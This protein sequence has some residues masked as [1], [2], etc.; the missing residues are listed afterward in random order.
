MT[1][2]IYQL[3]KQLFMIVLHYI[4][5]IVHIQ[6]RGHITPLSSPLSPLFPPTLQV[7][8]TVTHPIEKRENNNSSLL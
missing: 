1:S 2:N 7:S 3:H 8:M 5:F 6:L 4:I